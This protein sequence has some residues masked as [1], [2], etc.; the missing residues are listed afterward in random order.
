MPPFQ[1]EVSV[2]LGVCIAASIAGFVSLW[3]KE[4]AVKL[5]IHGDGE[6]VDPFDVTQPIDFVDGTP[7]NEDAFWERVCCSFLLFLCC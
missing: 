5:P 4:G 2:A 1:T 6:G 3:P 7:I